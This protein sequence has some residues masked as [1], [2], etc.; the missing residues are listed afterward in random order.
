MNNKIHHF[1]FSTLKLLQESKTKKKKANLA[2]DALITLL[3]KL[4]VL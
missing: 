2:K 3:R 1:I 4:Q